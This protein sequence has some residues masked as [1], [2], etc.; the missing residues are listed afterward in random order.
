MV[1]GSPCIEQECLRSPTPSPPS[2]PA[3]T[4]ATGDAVTEDTP[5]N[6]EGGGTL[7]GGANRLLMAMAMAEASVSQ[8]LSRKGYGAGDDLIT[9]AKDGPSC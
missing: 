1:G 5:V 4:S 8:L 2:W 3:G 9:G 7:I 6:F